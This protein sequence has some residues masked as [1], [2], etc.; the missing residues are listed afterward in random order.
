M[1]SAK[2]R[3][4]RVN[5]YRAWDVSAQ[6]Y[7]TDYDTGEFSLVEFDS[8]GLATVKSKE[9]TSYC[10]PDHPCGGCADIYIDVDKAIVEQFTGLVDT[11]GV[12]IY[13]GDIVR[14]Q[15]VISA[16]CNYHDGEPAFVEPEYIRIGHI[17]IRPSSGVCINGTMEHRDYSEDALI[18]KD[19]YS[20]NPGLWGDYA[21][22]IGNIH[23]DGSLLYT[24]S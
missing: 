14:H 18:S 5:K 24:D 4:V 7:V 11:N 9:L 6:H 12:D 1:S 15:R 3:P 22:V 16:P 19:K 17:T 2:E 21:E 13:E 20:G 8:K 10:N 23:E